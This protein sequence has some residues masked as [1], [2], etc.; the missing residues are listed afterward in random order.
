MA[1]TFDPRA[2]ANLTDEELDRRYEMRGKN[3]QLHNKRGPK[4]RAKAHEAV[5]GLVAKA[6]ASLDASL[7]A[8]RDL[9][10][11]VGENVSPGDVS[12]MT[13]DYLLLD[14]AFRQR[15]HDKIN[16]PAKPG[17]ANPFDGQAEWEADGTAIKA[18]MAA[19]SEEIESRR[20]ER[21]KQ[22]EALEKIA[23][24]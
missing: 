16:A 9:V 1:W 11:R 13:G 21:E 4:D 7:Y 6:E 24:R 19:I 20:L 15:L 2:L 10:S 5:E 14:P 3:L 18:E 23:S 12:G 17:E 8:F 22:K